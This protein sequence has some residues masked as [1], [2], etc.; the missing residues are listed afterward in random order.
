MYWKSEGITEIIY[1]EQWIRL[2]CQEL[3]EHQIEMTKMQRHVSRSHLSRF[4]IIFQL[5]L[6]LHPGMCNSGFTELGIRK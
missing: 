6:C 1:S 3:S 4:H 2:L 5:V